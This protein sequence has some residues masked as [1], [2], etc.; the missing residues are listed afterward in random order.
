MTG[1]DYSKLITPTRGPAYHNVDSSKSY[2]SDPIDRFPGRLAGRSRIWGDASPEVQRAG[3]D[4]IVKAARD[5]G[6][7]THDTALALAVAYHESGFNPDAAAGTSTATGLGQ[8]IDNTGKDYGLTDNNRWNTDDQAKALVN[9]FVYNR[10]LAAKRGLGEE[11]IYKF[12]HDGPAGESGGLKISQNEVMPL[13]PGFEKALNGGTGGIAPAAPQASD[14]PATKTPP[15]P[16]VAGI[17]GYTIQ[18]GDT[19]SGIAARH[20]VSV[21]D[22]AAANT[23]ADP[24]SIQAGKT[25]KMPGQTSDGAS[26]GS[27]APSEPSTPSAPSAAAGTLGDFGSGDT[28]GNQDGAIQLASADQSQGTSASTSSTAPITLTDS[29]KTELLPDFASWNMVLNGGGN[30]ESAFA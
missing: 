18:P 12:H 28:G 5:K 22:L 20:G 13:V 25:L 11:Y 19:L 14:A 21:G 8:F 30:A 17:G 3:I 24:D 2:Y 7:S 10:D 16:A 23:I 6:L 4:A 29:D 9:Y 27:A 15:P 1:I 26:P